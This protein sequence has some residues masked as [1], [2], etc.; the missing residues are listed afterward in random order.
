MPQYRAHDG[1]PVRRV[2]FMSH[3][4]PR[5]ESGSRALSRERDPMTVRKDRVVT[6]VDDQSG[7]PDLSE[8]FSPTVSGYER[9]I[10]SARVI[11]RPP[12]LANHE[13]VCGPASSNGRALPEM[14]RVPRTKKSTTD[15]SLDQS[16][17]PAP[18]K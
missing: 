5:E 4:L 14:T 1:V 2:K 16:I 15:A 10:A 6:A 7:N 18:A 11:G 9:V 12:H 8:S 3:S 17:P 13:I